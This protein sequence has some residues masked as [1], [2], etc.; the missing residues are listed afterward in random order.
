VTAHVQSGPE[1]ALVE[2]VAQAMAMTTTAL[3]EES[4]RKATSP[5][6]VE[7]PSQRLAW[8]ILLQ[9]TGSRATVASCSE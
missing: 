8:G 3:T 7:R 2:Q 9:A 1:T 5:S 4:R 6:H